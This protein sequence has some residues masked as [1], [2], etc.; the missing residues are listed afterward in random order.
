VADV[1]P[2]RGLMAYHA[3]APDQGLDEGLA[4]FYFHQLLSALV[5][6]A[7]HVQSGTRLMCVAQEYIHGQG[8]AHRDVK[9]ENLLLDA[10][11]ASAGGEARRR[12]PLRCRQSQAR[13][14]WPVQ[15]VQ[16][17]RAGARPAGS[18][19]QPTVH[20]TRGE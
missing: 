17:P 20:R 4:H 15:R 16:V 1:K 3:A 8:I 7:G 10:Q 19:W 13:R 2:Q 14:L 18:V 9:P 6:R 11:G 5:S 12:S